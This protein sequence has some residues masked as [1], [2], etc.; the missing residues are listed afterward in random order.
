MLRLNLVI[1]ALVL[2]LYLA[3]LFGGINI[4]SLF[5]KDIANESQ[6]IGDPRLFFGSFTPNEAG[7]HLLFFLFSSLLLLRKNFA[8]LSK[9]VIFI[10][11]IFTGSKT[12]ILAFITYLIFMTVCWRK[13]LYS[14][15]LVA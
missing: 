4:F 1:G 10:I 13:F 9:Y 8:N 15:S 11:S 6:W 3:D 5:V 12:V 14:F 2:A 7:H